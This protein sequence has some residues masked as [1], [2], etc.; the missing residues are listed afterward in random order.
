[1][2][3]GSLKII[4]VYILIYFLLISFTFVVLVSSC[5]SFIFSN[6][7]DLALRMVCSDLTV[8]PALFMLDKFSISHMFP[9]RLILFI[10]CIG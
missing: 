2:S 3:F 1:M 6:K 8:S 4:I 10:C 9:Y 7:A 5:Y